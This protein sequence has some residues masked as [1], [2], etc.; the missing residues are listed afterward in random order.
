MDVQGLKYVYEGCTGCK[1]CVHTRTVG[2][3]VVKYAYIHIQWLYRVYS[4]RTGCTVGV[5]G[6]QWAYRVY[7]KRTRRTVR[8][9]VCRVFRTK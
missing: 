8:D 7:H 5:Q 6:V 1:I 3:Q 9:M 2:V 4:G